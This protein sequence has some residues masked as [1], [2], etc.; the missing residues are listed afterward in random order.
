M[1]KP[2]HFLHDSKKNNNIQTNTVILQI[3]PDA[4]YRSN[5]IWKGKVYTINQHDGAVIPTVLLYNPF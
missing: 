4:L 3:P 5:N 2:T 1:L